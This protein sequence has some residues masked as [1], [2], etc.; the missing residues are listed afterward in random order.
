[1]PFAELDE[2]TRDALCLSVEWR[3]GEPVVR[4][5]GPNREQALRALERLHERLER[6]NEVYWQSLDEAAQREAQWAREEA[7][8][9]VEG[10]PG[11][12]MVW[13]TLPWQREAAGAAGGGAQVGAPAAGA[14]ANAEKPMVLSGS[15]PGPGL[16]GEPGVR[17]KPSAAITKAEKP[18]VLSGL[19]P[20]KGAG[21]DTVRT[22][23]SAR[24]TAGKVEKPK[25]LSG[26][27]APKPARPSAL[28]AV[29]AALRRKRPA[30]PPPIKRR[31][32]NLLWGG[33]PRPTGAAAR[34]PG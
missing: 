32:P 5:R 21:G 17:V 29:W 19:M 11:P 4:W 22:P 10:A 13:P 6:A 1:L 27:A 28:A 16:G 15:E 24:R 33:T 26:S 23:T 14:A 18:M 3:G 25:V 20:R 12:A 9:G 30:P 34:R 8:G 2:E 31:D 7:R